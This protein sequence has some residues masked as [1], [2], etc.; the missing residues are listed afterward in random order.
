LTPATRP[1]AELEPVYRAD[2]T[3]EGLTISVGSNG[4][5]T[6][7]DFAVYAAPQPDGGLQLAF[8][9]KRIDPCKSFAIGRTDLSFTWAE[10]GIPAGSRIALL[11]PLA[12]W[13]GP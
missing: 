8:G 11:N 9:R 5:T 2:A 6:K 3:R 12:V 4:C 1:F 13:R 10:L 7:G